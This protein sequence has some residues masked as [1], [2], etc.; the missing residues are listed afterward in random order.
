MFKLGD[1]LVRCFADQSYTLDDVAIGEE[2][3]FDYL[4]PADNSFFEAHNDYDSYFLVS[5]FKLVEDKSMNPDDIQVSAFDK[6][7]QVIKVLRAQLNAVYA[8]PRDK[9][10][11]LRV[12]AILTDFKALAEALET[13]I[14]A[15]EETLEQ[16]KEDLRAGEYTIEQLQKL[17]AIAKI[18]EIEGDFHRA[19]GQIEDLQL[20]WRGALRPPVNTWQAGDT[21][22][23]DHIEVELKSAPD[24]IFNSKQTL[25]LLKSL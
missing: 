5:D 9:A 1:K 6:E 17:I 23:I 11:V 3:T 15:L 18:G 22:N 2:V 25:A 7:T 8:L 19:H 10:F 14:P 16:T 24:V 20:N 12:E 4:H 13:E 21:V